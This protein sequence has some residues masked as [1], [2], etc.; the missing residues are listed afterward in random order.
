MA[1]ILH[2]IFLPIF[3]ALLILNLF[4]LFHCDA[5]R[6]DL[7]CNIFIHEFCELVNFFLFENIVVTRNC[8]F[9]TIAEGYT[10]KTKTDLTR[11]SNICTWMQRS[12]LT[13]MLVV[14]LEWFDWSWC[15]R[16][17]QSKLLCDHVKQILICPSC[18]NHTWCLLNHICRVNQTKTS[19]SIFDMLACLLNHWISLLHCWSKGNCQWNSGKFVF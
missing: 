15:I 4:V 17:C 14:V 1:T 6:F 5:V 9:E 12:N 13:S 19:K 16:K 18:A 2:A 10:C 3:L 8:N 7:I 11:K